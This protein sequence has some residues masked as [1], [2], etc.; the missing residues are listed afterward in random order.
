M[1]YVTAS[2]SSRADLLTFIQ[3]ACTANGWTL[4]GSIIH[5]GN[6]HIRILDDGTRLN[7]RAG[8][9]KDGSN[10]LTGA[11]ANDSRLAD[12]LNPGAVAYP[13]I[14]KAHI[15]TNPDEVYIVINY[16]VSYYQFAAWGQSDVPGLTGT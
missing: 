9:G 5:K 15:N 11:C 3:N 10:N 13:L 7:I 12:Y 8:T 14:A 16:S 2:V 6:V 4:S 1:A